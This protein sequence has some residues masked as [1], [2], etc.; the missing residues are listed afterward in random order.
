M[1][2][3]RREVQEG[4]TGCKKTES[5]VRQVREWMTYQASLTNVH[6]SNN[7]MY[8]RLVERCFKECVT[9]RWNNMLSCAWYQQSLLLFLCS[10]VLFCM[11]SCVE[12]P[13]FSRLLFVLRYAPLK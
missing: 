6:K 8:N 11:M 3:G 4:V 10:S 2:T 13:P 9:V 7:R 12:W 5:R 1:L